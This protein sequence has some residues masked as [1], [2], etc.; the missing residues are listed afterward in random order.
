V[1][2]RLVGV[3]SHFIY[4]EDARN[5]KPKVQQQ[6]QHMLF[7]FYLDETCQ[8]KHKITYVIQPKVQQQQMLFYFYLD[9]TCHD[10]HKITYVIH[11]LRKLLI[12]YKQVKFSNKTTKCARLP[13]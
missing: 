11:M 3:L 5:H 9:E 6:Q 8:D 2:V 1:I 10:K 13:F 4:L 12:N 7:Y